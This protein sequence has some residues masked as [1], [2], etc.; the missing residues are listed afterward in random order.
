[1]I[2]ISHRGNI[3]GRNPERENTVSYIQEALDQGF[4]VEVDVWKIGSKF[5]LG[6]DSAQNGASIDFLSQ[7][8]I[9]AHCKNINALESC[10]NS[11]IHCFFHDTDD[12]VLTSKQLLW[13]YPGK[14][15][16]RYAYRSILVLP[17]IDEVPY[18]Y[19]VCS[20]NILK[21]KK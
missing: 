4:N 5:Y 6:H 15:L 11:N 16:G 19:G 21:Y 17:E 2:L 13:V 14:S 1:M 7:N 3:N 12:V 9:I 18:C 8:G 20:D 10:V